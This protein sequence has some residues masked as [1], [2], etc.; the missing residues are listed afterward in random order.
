MTNHGPDPAEIHVLPQLWFRNVWTWGNEREEPRVKPHL[1]LDGKPVLAS[2]EKLGQYHFHAD[3]PDLAE[4]LR[5]LFTENETN[6]PVIY[7]TK[8]TT[9]YTKDAFHRFLVDGEKKAVSP[10]PEGTKTAALFHFVIPP[11]GSI[12][13]RCRLNSLRETNNLIGLDFRGVGDPWG[14]NS[15]SLAGATIQQRSVAMIVTAVVV[16]A[17]ITATKC[18]AAFPERNSPAASPSARPKC[19]AWNPTA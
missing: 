11:G 10:A 7:G 15:W 6:S 14:F 8:G 17:T 13:V 3:S 2:H 9:P 4:P 18:P 5:W 12:T 16:T 1:Q 19:A